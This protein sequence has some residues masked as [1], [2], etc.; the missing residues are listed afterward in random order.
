MY[1]DASPTAVP[2]G[3]IVYANITINNAQSTAT[4]ANFQQMINIT[5]STWGANIV[6][7]KNQANFEYFYSNGTIIP[8][9]IES[10]TSGKLITWAKIAPVMPADSNT[11]IFIGFEN[12]TSNT[13]SSTGT[14]G[15]GEAP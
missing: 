15:I 14:S 2:S 12:A 3:V 13:L 6:Y 11:V 7:G 5:E 9:W 1:A 8:A 10:N 4:P